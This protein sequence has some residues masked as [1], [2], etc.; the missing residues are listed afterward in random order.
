MPTLPPSQLVR[1]GAFELDLRAAEL[2]K[3]GLK[4]RLQEQ[5]FLILQALLENP[6]QVVTSEE[7][8][9]KIWP[10]DTFVDFDHGLHAAVRRL[11]DAL[12]DSADNPRYIE[13]VARRGYRFIGQIQG[14]ADEPSP[15]L[16][17][18]PIPAP[19]SGRKPFVR[20]SWTG[21][22][23]G[24]L[25]VLVI[26]I[27]LFGF[28]LKAI[29]NR[30]SSAANSPR[31]FR[32]LAVLPLEN[33]SQDPTQQPWADEMTEELITEFSKL[34]KLRVI[35]RT[36]VMQYKGTRKP[37]PQIARELNV[38]AVVEGAVQLA[39]DRVRI[40]A[41]LVDGATDEHIWA[42]SYDRELS[43]V[44]LLQ[45]D[46]AHDIAQ[47]IALELTPQDQQRLAKDAHPVV[48]EAYQA[49]LLGR[50]YWNKR[51]ADG[52]AKAGQYFQQAIQKDPNYA[53]AYSGLSDYFA[54][55][56]LIGGPEI[57]PPRDAMTKA[58]AA[59]LKALELDDSSAE[60]HASMGHV[61]HNYD[62]DW[63][64][65]Q[66]EFRRAIELNPNYALAHHWYAHYLMQL[67]RTDESLAEA[68][69]AQELDPYSPFI[70]NGLARQYYLARQYD[71]AIIQCQ[72]SLGIDPAYLPARLQLGLAY[73][74]K[75]ML[76]EAVSEFELA[77]KFAAGYAK[78]GN[79]DSAPATADPK[80]DL[81]VVHAMLAQA[82]AKA[83]RIADAQKESLVLTAIGRSRY[84]PPSYFAIVTAALGNKNQAFAYLEK[85]YDDRSEQILYMG[86]EPLVDPLRSDPRFDSL[87]KRVGLKR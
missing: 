73:E 86:V 8:Q 19:S 36:S 74:Q 31:S 49:Y 13:T 52:L 17:I 28:N 5:P 82:Y 29:R 11:R 23:G 40:T 67:G 60:A 39:G 61:L 37:L 34:P 33:L 20:I 58:K 26:G 57:L 14:P 79:P 18:I 12:S 63:S 53:L 35:S 2:R 75:G 56:T 70:N 78:T 46:V 3:S 30:F 1:F 48:P 87:L 38:D 55:L 10:A 44:L 16:P 15:L 76:T 7:L 66:R 83:G 85:S 25:L 64:G 71:K 77:R 4:L 68:R 72:V 42:Q 21:M 69:R 54:F 47:Q 9:K 45:S 6:G 22:L 24:F 81:P 27:A 50:Y 65:A 62:W 84:V 32:S 43:D 51:T 80:T 41:Q 59:A